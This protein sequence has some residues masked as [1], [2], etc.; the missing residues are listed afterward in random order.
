MIQ[1]RLEDIS[2]DDLIAFIENQVREGRTIEYKRELP[3]GSN[4][5]KKELLA[6]VSSFANTSGGDLIFG[7]EE[8]K[9][10]P[11]QVVGLRSGDLDAE[12]LRLESI[13]DAGLEPRIRR[14]LSV[15][16]CGDGR[17]VIILR[18]ARSWSG[19]HR[20]IF[21]QH[22]KFWGRNDAGKF[23]L[24]IGELR[25]AFTLSSTTIE[26]IRGFRTDRI[27]AISNNETPVPMNPGPKMVMHCIPVESFAGQ[28]N[29]DVMPFY[30]NHALLPAV[31]NSGYGRRL[32][33]DGL[34]VGDG[35]RTYIGD[36]YTHLYRN[37][38]IEVVTGPGWTFEQDKVRRM[39]SANYEWRLLQYLP[40]CFRVFKEIGA[41]APIYVSLTMT[42]ARGLAMADSQSF[43]PFNRSFLINRETLALPESVVQDFSA[44][45][46]EILKPMFDLI[47][48]ACGYQG[49]KN[50]NKDG[51]FVEGRD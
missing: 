7:V 4:D 12:I 6:D 50:F 22:D 32:D 5:A 26:R 41:N 36:N 15:V 34:V 37:G 39:A 51:L 45:P 47:W 43:N 20:V 28:P 23:R 30:Q 16:G 24:D 35:D 17:R 9:G 49:S 18:I 19:P 48:N 13:M 14:R 46:V 27:I 31:G 1:K 42:N 44:K 33:L 11:T 21:Q 40:V 3:G 2:E 8:D 38:I 29:Y 25:S 10:L